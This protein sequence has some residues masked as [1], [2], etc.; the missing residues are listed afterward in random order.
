[1]A[2]GLEILPD[3]VR[4]VQH[5]AQSGEMT[6]SFVLKSKDTALSQGATV[7]T[8]LRSLEFTANVYAWSASPNGKIVAVALDSG[9]VYVLYRLEPDAL[10][11]SHWDMLWTR[12]HFPSAVF[13][14][15]DAATIGL[16]HE[17]NLHVWKKGGDNLWREEPVTGGDLFGSDSDMRDGYSRFEHKK[18]TEVA[19][20]DA[21]G[22][23]RYRWR[24]SRFLWWH[25]W[26]RWE[27][28]DRKK[29]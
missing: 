8:L 26:R 10:F 29:M 14:T 6:Y 22:I 2:D 13:I 7:D 18:D 25:Y 20:I 5:V 16:W 4:T 21:S 12:R 15:N 11:T 19:L 24:R 28:R 17:H 9:L 3:G 23:E 27:V 1:M